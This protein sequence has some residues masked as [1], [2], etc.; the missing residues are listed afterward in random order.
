MK[1][2]NLFKQLLPSFQGGVGGSLLMGLL[3]A[4]FGILTVSAQKTETYAVYTS[5]NTTLTFY[6]DNLRSSRTGTSYDLNT[7]DDYPGWYN[8][9]TYSQV[10]KVVFDALFVYAR[11]TGTYY[12]FYG[13]NHLANII[14]LEYLNTSESTNLGDMFNG[15]S[16]LTSIDLSGFNTAN[17]TNMYCMFLGC[18]SL[19]TLDLASFNT[20]KVVNMSGMF[21]NCTALT[22]I[23]VSDGWS[24]AKALSNANMFYNCT[25]LRGGNGTTYD[26]NNV[27][28]TY[29]RIDGGIS[30]PGYFTDFSTREAYAELSSNNTKLTFYYDSQ[31]SSRTG[32]TYTINPSGNTPGWHNNITNVTNVVFAPSF[33]SAR[34]TTTYMWFSNMTNLVTITGIQY[35][36]TSRV[37]EMKYM[38]F[39]C[40]KLTTIDLSG[41]NTANVTNMYGLFERCTSLTSLDVSG[42]NTGKVTEMSD[43]FRECSALS[44][45]NLSNWNTA[46]VTDMKY[47]FEECRKLTTLNLSSWNTAKVTNMSHMFDDCTKLKTI[48]VGDS[49]S[50]ASVTESGWMFSGCSNLVGGNGTAFDVD[51]IDKEY[52]RVDVD[53]YPGYLTSYMSDGAEPYV[54][55]SQDK[56]TLTFYF[57]NQ[58]LSRPGTKYPIEPD[59]VPSWII[60]KE[61]ITTVEFH[62]LF[63]NYHG[64]TST[65]NMFA[66]LKNLTQINHLERLN[67]EN[68]TDMSSMFKGCS[69]LTSL[70]LFYFNTGHVTDM[71][72]MF[73]GCSSLTSLFL[74]NFN[75][76]NVRYMLRMFEGCSSLRTLDLYSFDTSKVKDMSAMFKGCNSLETITNM[77]F[78][79]ENVTDMDYL[80]ADCRSLTSL[81]LSSFN[82]QN[83]TSMGGMFEGCSLLTTLNL[84]NFYTSNVTDMGNM[85]NGCSS[86]TSIE[87]RTFDTSKVTLMSN[88]FRN[89]SSL[90]SLNLSYLNTEN[91]Y[92][93]KGMFEGCGCP[94]LDVTGFNT[95]KVVNTESMF[96]NISATSLNLLNFDMSNIVNFS[97]MFAGASNLTTIY[98]EDTWEGSH[99]DSVFVGCTSLVGSISYDPAKISG[100]YANPE[101]GYFS[102]KSYAVL[103]EDGKTLT[104][105]HDDKKQTRPGTK[106]VLY[107]Y[108]GWVGS[109]AN[110]NITTVVFDGDFY[111]ARPTKT[112][113]WFYNM[114]NL[115]T[116]T[117]L[118]YLNTSQVTDMEYMFCGCSKL[119]TLDLSRFNTEKVT[120]MAAMFYGMSAITKLNLGAFNPQNVT[121]MRSMFYGDTQL[122]TIYVSSNK[123]TTKSVTTSA[124]MFT[125]CTSLVGGNGTTYNSS[126]TNAAYAIVDGTNG[127]PGYLTEKKDAYA[128]QSTDKKTLTFYYDYMMDSREG[129]VYEVPKV[130]FNL[131]W[132]SNRQITTVDF[133]ESFADYDGLT[134]TFTM[135]GDMTALTEINHLD[136]LNT[137]NVTD[138]QFM[139]NGC[140]ALKTLDLS[141][142]NMAKVTTMSYM[143][144]GCPA[145]TTIYVGADWDVSNVN[146]STEMF[147][148]CTSLKGGA[149]TAYNDANPKDKTYARIDGLNNQ[150]GYFSAKVEP[151][152]VYTSGNSTLTFYRDSQRYTRSGVVYSLN[153]GT[154]T[155]GW[156]ANRTSITKVVFNSS[157]ADARPTTTYHWFYGMTNL[158]TITYI[159]YLNTSEVTNMSGMF[160]DCQKFTTLNLSR[161]NT[162]NVTDM[163]EMFRSCSGLTTLD[164]SS[165]NTANVTD[166]YRMFYHCTKLT[167]LVIPAGITAARYSAGSRR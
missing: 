115:E 149:G 67:T 8:D 126:Y 94:T 56:K 125:G 129:T 28:R 70:N 124:G 120:T 41:F 55:L 121:D 127:N 22:T 151:Y 15:C 160:Y 91:V 135:F 60:N 122:T 107:N 150:P 131:G 161:F 50:T 20:E 139:F 58:K 162:E 93:M 148:G 143:F 111:Y 6:Y 1:P 35:L 136:R 118:K 63:A 97:K 109:G 119:T 2:N 69:K 9:H 89:C 90:E 16:S 24:T 30:K 44:S 157:F 80:F 4:L 82:T 36:N 141:G 64:L 164:V 95:S 11:P 159:S 104:F 34:P 167:S 96:A 87:L 116:I 52:A 152:A 83:V 74:S 123:W 32:T 76:S 81:S 53:G 65:K 47:M 137:E 86:L 98:C 154:E 156:Y 75:T 133:D 108:P 23:Y 66:G 147:T 43:L 110:A 72:D 132:T 153:E 140:T 163:S 10:T 14:G 3:F 102:S 31:R 61:S 38:F 166:M 158:T 71:N 46:K 18:T 49:W 29:A 13:M 26:E 165:F 117:N 155:P 128:V 17:V 144:Y 138:M 68:V 27:G 12:W 48:M 99:A 106:Y 45:L 146:N 40:N 112:R 39:G 85:F 134:S 142:F 21:R 100:D 37:I 101:T 33:A 5:N 25:S 84:G 54:A 92:N 77:H 73:N 88:M 130:M 62:E 78:N 79:T 103:S 7:G 145:L 42:F 114:K 19:T 59:L 105:Y 113:A 57:D 51:H